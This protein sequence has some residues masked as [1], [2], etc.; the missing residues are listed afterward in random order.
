M[1]PRCGLSSWFLVFDFEVQLSGPFDRQRNGARTWARRERRE[2]TFLLLSRGI[3]RTPFSSTSMASSSLPSLYSSC[4]KE[5]HASALLHQTS[6]RFYTNCT[7]RTCGRPV[8]E[9]RCCDCK[10]FPRGYAVFLVL[11]FVRSLL[12]LVPGHIIRAGMLLARLA[13][14]CHHEIRRQKEPQPA[15]RNSAR[16]SAN[17]RDHPGGAPPNLLVGAETGVR[18]PYADASSLLLPPIVTARRGRR[19]FPS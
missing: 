17:F 10:A 7:R 15:Q 1:V 9:A 6:T 5:Y 3:A 8:R 12:K 2:A 4:A 11:E 18:Q 13:P 16:V 14:A 19:R